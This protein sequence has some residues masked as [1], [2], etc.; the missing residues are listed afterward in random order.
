[1][2]W[3]AIFNSGKSDL[4][5]IERDATAR[6]NGYTVISYR[7]ALSDGLLPT[8][9]YTR[10]FQQDNARIHNFGGM[11]QRLQLHEIDVI[12]WPCSISLWLG[13]LECRRLVCNGSG[14][15]PH[16]ATAMQAVSYA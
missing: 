7:N 5:V 3:A 10:P 9:H 8:Y 6:R 13:I 11:P 1:M 16:L 12:E 4:V 14:A 2:V 15:R